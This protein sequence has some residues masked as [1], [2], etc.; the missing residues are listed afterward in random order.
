MWLGNIILL[1]ENSIES[2]EIICKLYWEK[3]LEK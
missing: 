3:Y 2:P 1:Q